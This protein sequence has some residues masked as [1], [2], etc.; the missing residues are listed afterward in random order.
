MKLLAS[1]K[2][3]LIIMHAKNSRLWDEYQ[4]KLANGNI[5]VK[6]LLESVEGHRKETSRNLS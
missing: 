4:K 2:T 3:K 1:I 5:T 6:N